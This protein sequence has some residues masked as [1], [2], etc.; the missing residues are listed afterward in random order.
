MT[1]LSAA[2]GA[3]LYKQAELELLIHAARHESRCDAKITRRLSERII[4]HERSAHWQAFE[5]D[6]DRNSRRVAT[7]AGKTRTV[8]GCAI[9]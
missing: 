6:C 8:I 7:G 5:K 9:C 1:E 2:S 3:G 4:R